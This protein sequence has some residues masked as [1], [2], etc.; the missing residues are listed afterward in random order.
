MAK[1]NDLCNEY[2]LRPICVNLGVELRVELLFANLAGSF[3]IDSSIFR[4]CSGRLTSRL[5]AT[6]YETS[7]RIIIGNET[8]NSRE[9]KT[10]RH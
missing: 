5:T 9:T 4:S 1:N 7:N 3:A 10:Q 8:T 2:G 6:H